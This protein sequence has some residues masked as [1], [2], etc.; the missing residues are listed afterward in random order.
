MN[1]NSSARTEAKKQAPGRET[2]KP[3]NPRLGTP[4]DVLL[5]LTTAGATLAGAAFLATV[6]VTNT[7]RAAFSAEEAAALAWETP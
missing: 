5:A 4:V 2:A 1:T 3:T 7:A 6:L